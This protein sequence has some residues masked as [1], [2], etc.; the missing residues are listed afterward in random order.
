MNRVLKLSG[1]SPLCS[2]AIA[3]RPPLRL[4]HAALAANPASKAES[5][6]SNFRR[7]KKLSLLLVLPLPPFPI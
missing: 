4:L 2:I 7:K 6:S 5:E 3:R 1:S